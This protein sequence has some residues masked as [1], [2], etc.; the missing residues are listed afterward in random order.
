MCGLGKI[1][2][3]DWRANTRL[4][5]CTADS[6]VVKWFWKAVESFDEERRAR[7]LQ[8]VTGSSRV[9]LQGFKAL[10]GQNIHI[11]THTQIFKQRGQMLKERMHLEKEKKS[12]TMEKFHPKSLKIRH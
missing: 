6:N 2:I 3:Q 5:H 9:P 10:Q 1:D 12:T 8:F 11:H 7:L 4:K